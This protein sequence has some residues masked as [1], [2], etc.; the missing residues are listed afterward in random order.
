MQRARNRRRAHGEHVHV[1]LE[2]LD[3]LLMTNAETLL[4]IHH[5]EAEVAK[6]Y[7]LRK[8]AVRSDD[9]V[10]FAFGQALQDFGDFLLIAKTAEHFDAHWKGGEAA[11]ESFEV[12]I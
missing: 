8:H 3:A 4:F 9:D 12:L 11:L 5:Q 2:L 6:D 7:V 10:H 1:V